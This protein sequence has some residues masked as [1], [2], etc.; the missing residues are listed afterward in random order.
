M[1]PTYVFILFLCLFALSLESYG[2]CDDPSY[3]Y[4]DEDGDG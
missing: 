1:K 2:Q 3:F 4:I